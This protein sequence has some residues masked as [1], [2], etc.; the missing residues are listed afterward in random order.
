[1]QHSRFDASILLLTYEQGSCVHDALASL[2]AQDQD[3]VEIV[4]SDD[5]SSDGTWERL[6]QMA[7]SYRGPKRLLLHR[8]DSNLGIVGN[9]LAASQHASSELL[10]IAHGDDVSLPNRCSRCLEFRHAHG[11]RHD[12]VAADAFDMTFDGHVLGIKQVDDLSAWNA[13]RWASER[14][15]V[16]G[17]AQLITRRLLESTPLDPNL[18]CEDQVLGFRAVMRGSGIRLPE[19]LIRHRRGGL[20]QSRVGG[21]AAKRRAL[22][23]SARAAL[24]EF[25]Q[26][27]RDAESAGCLQQ[28][29]SGFE[30][31]E[32]IESY[33]A[34][35]LAGQLEVGPRLRRCVTAGIPWSKRLRFLAWS[36]RG[37]PQGPR[38]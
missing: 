29:R 2:L 3:R 12:L 27:R 26:L 14:P 18:A 9:L 22:L 19:P 38:A 15:F 23:R 21:S 7:S 11:D 1:M 36:F 20:S 28:I 4:V 31:Q 6:Q 16:L 13:E 10:F 30:A 17:A 34:D 24:V 32:R 33:I 37:N 5:C 35:M 25:E 8:N